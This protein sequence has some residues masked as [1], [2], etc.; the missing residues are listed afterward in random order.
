[1]NDLYLMEQ[2]EEFD[3]IENI[4][5]VYGIPYKNLQQAENVRPNKQIS[6]ERFLI[7]IGDPTS[8]KN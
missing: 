6:P 3:E 1:M 7:I 8:K 2:E 4:P 5:D